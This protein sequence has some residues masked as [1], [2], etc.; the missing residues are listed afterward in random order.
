VLELA[1]KR[2]TGK[3]A[4]LEVIYCMEAAFD[5]GDM[6]LMR[7]VGRQLPRFIS[8]AEDE[9]VRTQLLACLAEFRAWQG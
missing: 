9:T 3:F 1:P 2:F 6:M 4:L 8:Q 5:T 7:R